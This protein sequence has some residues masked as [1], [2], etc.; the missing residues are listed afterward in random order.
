MEKVVLDIKNDLNSFGKEIF[1]V[2]FYVNGWVGQ[3]EK[4]HKNAIISTFDIKQIFDV[5]NIKLPFLKI[6]KNTCYKYNTENLAEK[7][8]ILQ[9]S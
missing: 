7:M 4:L 6:E 1:G 8:P 3:Y 9:K 2:S 5:E